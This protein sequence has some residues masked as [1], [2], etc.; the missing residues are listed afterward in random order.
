M[1]AP[2]DELK[3]D[4]Y[5]FEIIELVEQ[6]IELKEF[7]NE[8]K[9]N[10][11]FKK[12]GIKNIAQRKFSDEQVF[13]I[14]NKKYSLKITSKEIAVLFNC[15][16]TTIKQIVSGKYYQECYK[17]YFKLQTLFFKSL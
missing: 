13:N 7:Q 4:F 5:N 1:H 14:L 3:S 8:Q 11:S 2:L 15:S 17:L 9:Q 12:I 16:L 6:E 10:L